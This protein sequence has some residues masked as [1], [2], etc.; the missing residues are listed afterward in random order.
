MNDIRVPEF[1]VEAGGA[2]LVVTKKS[3]WDDVWTL[4]LPNHLQIEESRRLRVTSF[5]SARRVAEELA[6]VLSEAEDRYQALRS[7][8]SK[9]IEDV[10]TAAR[11]AG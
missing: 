7:E 10:L 5:D 6:A 8:T 1:S 9:R 4:V 2:A 11:D 3:E